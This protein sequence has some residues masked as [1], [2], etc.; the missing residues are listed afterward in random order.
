[1]CEYNTKWMP[2]SK[3]LFLTGKWDKSNRYDLWKKFQDKNLL[4][5]CEYSL[6]LPTDHPDKSFNKNLD[7]CHYSE[8]HKHTSAI[9]FDHTLYQKTGFRV[10]SET[11]FEDWQLQA[12]PLYQDQVNDP[13]LTEKT[14]LPILNNQPFIM[15][16]QKGTLEKLNQKGYHTF[17]EHLPHPYDYLPDTERLDAIVA[18]TEFWI[19]NLS[20]DLE[21]R[22]QVEENYNTFIEQ[23]EHDLG[24]IYN[25]I[26]TY[27]LE[28]LYE[29][30][31]TT[32]FL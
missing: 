29:D 1:M 2:N 22:K 17:E 11:E 10:V 20:E 28:C 32:Q 7:N 18:N 16:G 14:W 15:A 25:I 31:V 30:I 23:S 19:H 21:I 13:W 3:F 8:L 12:S 27:D 26:S 5:Y 9:P 4:D 6:F 24:V